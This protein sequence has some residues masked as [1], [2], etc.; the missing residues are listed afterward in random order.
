MSTLDRLFRQSTG[1]A[2]YASQYALY[3]SRL[4][5]ELDCEAVE[6]VG[7]VFEKARVA[8]RTIFLL[9]N[10]GSASTASHFANDLGLGPRVLGGSAF[11]ALSLTD[12]NAFVTAAGNDLGYETIFVEQLKTLM[13]RGD[14]VVGISASGNSP[15]VVKAIEYAKAHRAFTVGLTGFSGGKLR[16]L[17]DEAIH[18]ATPAG[19][20]GPVED[21]HLVLDH[22]LT[23]YLAR[24]TAGIARGEASTGVVDPEG[25]AL[26]PSSTSAAFQTT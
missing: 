4:L 22:L 26:A 17:V 16:E 18:I 20:Y 8:G 1:L 6:R 12:N 15:N 2:D 14:V 11:R 24:L 10:G 19:D 5:A 23:S 21:L 9:G 13:V 7:G 3:L 25:V